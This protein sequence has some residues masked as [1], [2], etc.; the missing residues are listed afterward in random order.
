VSTHASRRISDYM[1]GELD[2]SAADDVE[3]HLARCAWCRGILSDF[4]Q[5]VAIARTL[6]VPPVAGD[7][8]PAIAAHVEA[9]RGRRLYLIDARDSSARV[10]RGRRSYDD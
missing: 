8:W 9:G 1:D 7:L 5:I 6:D 2:P 10:G 3:R 4:R